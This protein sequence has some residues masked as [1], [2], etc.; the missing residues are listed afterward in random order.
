MGNI[1][2]LKVV[3]HPQ[4]TNNPYN[5][6]VD[7]IVNAANNALIQ[8]GGVCQAIFNAAGEGL[9]K[10][11]EQ[12]NGCKTG[13]AKVTQGYNIPV[14]YIIHKVG[15]IWDGGNSDED[16]LL[17]SCHEA[18]L[19]LAVKHKLQTVAFPCIS[20]GSFGYPPTEASRVA[21]KAVANF[22]TTHPELKMVYFVTNRDNFFIYSE[23]VGGL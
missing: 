11:C 12:L 8:G 3:D 7:A 15:P 6:K 13:E 17:A 23:V 5:L 19:R 21:V 1:A 22:L 2:T 9:A 20:T 18:S 10:E 4:T 16:K 14:K